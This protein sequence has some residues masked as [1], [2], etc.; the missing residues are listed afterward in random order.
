MKNNVGKILYLLLLIC[1]SCSSTY[2]FSIEVQE[3]AMITLPVSAQNVLILNNT[4]TQ[5]SDH[6]IERNINGNSIS[7]DYPL[8]LDS[9]V[10]SAMDEIAV[11]FDESDFFNTVATYNVPVR[12]DDEWLSMNH[13]SPEL[14][15]NLYDTDNFDAL[16]VIERLFLFLK[17]NVKPI[18][19]GAPPSEQTA[20]I[21]LRADGVITCSMYVYGNEKPFITFQVSDSLIL[22]TM[23][24]ND[25]ITIF[26]NIP[27]YTFNVLSIELGNKVAKCF[28]PTWKTE[29]RSLFVN[30]DSRMQEA[31]GYA[32]NSK[33]TDAESIWITEFEK[34]TKPA[35]KAKIAF[36]LAVANEMQDRFEPALD[37]ARKAKEYIES[38]RTKNDSQEIELIDNYIPKI[39][40]RIKS[41]QLLDLQWGEE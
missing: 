32:A 35:D 41:N 18:N 12:E 17:E 31:A 37:W 19:N 36:N 30:F 24:Y 6:G 38:V 10:W 33:W 21:D 39:E 14:Q 5:P 28:I 23:M 1:S 11:I 40:Q 16:F 34:K 29:K 9:T 2:R 20:F 8:S 7:A 26:K 27:E 4:V 25:S 15:S 22:K 13:L 3:P